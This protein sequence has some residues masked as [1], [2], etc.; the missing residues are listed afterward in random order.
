LEGFD[1]DIYILPETWVPEGEQY[2][3]PPRVLQWAEM[4]DKNIFHARS[5]G[6]IRQD[7]KTRHR[8]ELHTAIVTSF[9]MLETREFLL[10]KH[11]SDPSA[12]R[13]V[14]AA[15]LQ[16]TGNKP[17]WVVGVHLSS[18]V[19]F[20]PIHNVRHLRKFI[21]QLSLDGYPIV[22]G[23]DFNLW[24]WWVRIF[25]RK[26]FRRAVRGTSWPSELP[27]SQIDH[28]LISEGITLS[29]GAV[30]QPGF[31]DHRAIVAEIKL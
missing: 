20:V 24:G 11:P 28:I 6:V 30:C 19:T 14:V 3:L 2:R 1:A 12:E 21:K 7:G 13:K 31:S 23:G 18:R 9:P 10:P 25:L 22:I 17:L 15:L 27:H 29:S 8:G 4:E 16:T 5:V 26:G